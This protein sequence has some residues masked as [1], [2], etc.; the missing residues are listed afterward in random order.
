MTD[1][2]QRQSKLKHALPDVLQ[3]LSKRPK[4][5]S[6]Q[7]QGTTPNSPGRLSASSQ[8]PM[9][10]SVVPPGHVPHGLSYLPA[11]TAGLE[12]MTSSQPAMEPS[13]VPSHYAASESTYQPLG[14][15]RFDMSTSP[16]RTGWRVL[17]EVLKAV[18]DGSDLFLPLKAALVGV[19]E[20]MDIVD[21]LGEA[22][23]GFE[24]IAQNI[25]HLLQALSPYGSEQHVSPLVRR[26]L[27]RI[28]EFLNRIKL[29]IEYKTR[30]SGLRRVFESWADVEEVESVFRELATMLNEFQLECNLRTER[31]V[32]DLNMSRLLAQL[33]H[34]PDAGIDAQPGSECM[35]DT[36][37]ALLDELKVWSLD[38]AAPRIFWLDGM[39]G[40][41]K[42]AIARSL[43]LILR[44]AGIFG[45]SF[46]CSRG[47]N[48]DDI[49]RI[50]PTLAVSLAYQFPAYK[51]AL[52]KVLQEHPDA[53]HERVEVQVE[54]LL[55][56]PLCEAFGN[57]LPTVVLVIDALDECADKGA[58]TII[59]T[60][61]LQVSSRMPIKFFVTSRPE[62]HI[63][64]QFDRGDANIRRILRLHDIEHSI[65]EKD[66][67]LYIDHR[68]R[69]MRPLEVASGSSSSFP[70]EWPTREDIATLA[71]Q[72]GKLF[73]YAF[74]ATEYI[75]GADPVER[76]QRFTGLEITAGGPMNKPLDDTYTF[77]L[78]EALDSKRYEPEELSEVRQILAAILT[79]REHLS[80]DV[81]AEVIGISPQRIRTKLQALHAVVYV[82]PLD[83][84]GV[85]STFHASFGDFLTTP[86]RAGQ[87]LIDRQAVHRDLADGCIRI[88]GSD[89]LHF[90]VSGCQTSYLPN[91]NQKCAALPKQLTYACMYWY[92]HID[93]LD[94]ALTQL[95]CLSTVLFRK[96][97]FWL[98]VL[99][100]LRQTFEVRWS[101]DRLLDAHREHMADGTSQ[102]FE[103]AKVFVD[104][105]RG[106]IAISVPHIYLSALPS[107]HPSSRIA[108]AF[109]PEFL[110]VPVIVT[111]GPSKDYNVLEYNDDVPELLAVALSPDGTRI[112]SGSED[113]TM[114][115]WVASTGQALLEPL[116]GHAGE[117]TSVAFS[118]DGTRIVSGSWDKTIRIWD[119]R[120]GQALLEPL[121]GHTRQVTSVAF[122][123]DGTRIV[124]GSY[125]ATIRIW[126]ASTGQALLEPLAGHTSLVTS[127][128][129]SPDGT[130]I[131]S[132][133]LDETIRIWDASTGQALLEPLKG[134]TRQVTSVAFS[135]DGTRIASGSQDKTIRI[136]DARTGQ[137]L[138]EPLEGHTRQVTSVAF[139]PDGTR[140]ASGSHDGTIRIWDASTGQALLRPLKGHTSWV[141]SVAFSPD[142]TRVVSGSEDGTIR[143]WDVGT[144]QA[145]PQSLQGHSESI[146]SVVFSDGT[147][148]AS[149]SQ[150]MAS[151]GNAFSSSTRPR[152]AF[153]PHIPHL[154]LAANSLDS[155]TSSSI[156]PVLE[157]SRH[158]FLPGSPSTHDDA[159]SVCI[160]DSFDPLSLYDGSGIADPRDIFS[161]D[162]AGWITGPQGELILW[163]PQKYHTELFYI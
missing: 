96:F 137:A 135:P 5:D 46:F 42:S 51:W 76:L 7:T 94:D 35:Q 57:A 127:V 106:V 25:V 113:N 117:V 66:I 122:S 114:R 105:C 39:A 10:G 34:V 11:G 58:T 132:G 118:P 144:A 64:S 91:E 104:A 67:Y 151:H 149:R 22:R 52:L 107:V 131:V 6:D 121:E 70:P 53:G 73:I 37:V 152:V 143:I 23:D 130:R 36:R 125:D 157:P 147:H 18:K 110:N 146:S 109:W 71:L 92:D 17:K 140:I 89:L 160:D 85:V 116:E 115:I 139:S 14:V 1:P 111:I 163:I 32:E 82:P 54:R 69:E 28:E 47:T 49:K 9:G 128:A 3:R 68:L 145:L 31:M 90:N 136:W 56:G 74:T 19:V 133:S 40:T 129:F 24:R 86:E 60:H 159:S 93:A 80:L 21:N 30:R 72:A 41:G 27:D 48:R 154:P 102:F 142:G 103:D 2:T 99:S 13:V 148:V 33:Q 138:L 62:Q 79:V 108:E 83:H 98:E 155:D 45:G 100:T 120:T 4:T 162:D 59:L 141:D 61:L 12:P 134:H 50:I 43:C 119:A 16:S 15:S 124:S 63:R 38:S 84:D 75:Q 78:D 101:L 150:T 81:L 97:L 87:F 161:L 44:R 112:A 123:P 153:S 26:R 20:V 126:D 29:E 88:M 77:I 55:Q 8:Q 95:Q 156:L 65:V 158:H